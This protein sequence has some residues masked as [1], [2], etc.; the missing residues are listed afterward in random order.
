MGVSASIWAVPLGVLLGAAVAAVFAARRLPGQRVLWLILALMSLLAAGASAAALV[1]GLTGTPITSALYFGGSASLLALMATGVLAARSLPEARRDG[2]LEALI[3]VVLGAT[4]CVYFVL[5][6]GFRS[7]DDVLTAVFLVDLVALALAVVCGVA[8]RGDPRVTWALVGAIAAAATGDG[9]ISAGAADRVSG[10][11]LTAAAMWATAGAAFLWAAQVATQ[12][13]AQEVD[14][15]ERWLASRILLPFFA[16]VALPEIALVLWAAGDLNPFSAAFFGAAFVLVLLLAFARQAYLLRDNRRAI[17]RE[18]EHATRDPLTGVCNRRFFY[19]ALDKEVSRHERY[20]SLASIVIFDIDDFKSINDTFGHACGDEAL[21]K[22]CAIAHRQIRDVDTFARLGGE[23]F[24]LLLPE[25]PPLD[26]LLVA[27]R[28]RAAVARDQVI[29]GRR[30]TL[31]GGVAT[32]PQ[33]ALTSEDLEK[34]ADAALYWAKRNGKNICAVASEATSPPAGS[35]PDVAED[36]LTHL[37]ELVSTIDAEPLHTRDHSENVAAY[38]VA[39][40]QALGLAEEHVVRL[41]RAAFFHDIG[42]VAVPR[43]TL[44]TPGHLDA[45]GWAEIRLHPGVGS[46]MLAYAGLD[47]EAV[48]VAQHHEQLDGCGYPFGLRGEEIA[49][50]ARIILV[51]DAFEAMTADRPH[52]AGMPVDAAVAELRRCAGAQFDEGVVSEMAGLIE[53]DELAVVTLR[54]PERDPQRIEIS[55]LS[56]TMKR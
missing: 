49:L 10:A 30:V 55:E 20:G 23:E 16:V 51:A 34:E 56:P 4:L 37:Y 28:V 14:P 24:G 44:G 38:A 19:E 22:V 31:S 40:G 1:S 6:P 2:V 50:E 47:E 39:L 21:L 13:P 8:G 29:P 48:W 7:G 46:S 33:D 15:G 27:D 9:V 53:R 25:T 5:V 52:R 54:D 12:P 41:R 26:A 32:C 17:A 36:K 3:F 35:G 45:A 43:A 42:T 11:D 18:R